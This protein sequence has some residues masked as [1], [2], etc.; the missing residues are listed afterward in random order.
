V[1]TDVVIWPFARLPDQD[2]AA[3]DLGVFS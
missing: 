1:V 3:K 2:N